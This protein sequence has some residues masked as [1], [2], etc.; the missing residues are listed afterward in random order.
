M[1]A[2]GT[3]NLLLASLVMTQSLWLLM[4]TR[5]AGKVYP[6]LFLLESIVIVSGMFM[7]RRARLMTSSSSWIWLP[8][9][10]R[11][12]QPLTWTMSTLP[13]PVTGLPSLTSCLSTPGRT[14]PSTEHSPWSPLWLGSS[15]TM[16]SSGSS[17]KPR[18]QERQTIL[19][20]LLFLPLVQ[21]LR[22]GNSKILFLLE[23]WRI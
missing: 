2:R 1:E 19:T 21:P 4:V 5:E 15:T 18:Q 22:W 13:A 12:S 7:L 6:T 16:T 23:D 9:L 8:R 17:L 20:L 3:P 11:R 10:V 14:D